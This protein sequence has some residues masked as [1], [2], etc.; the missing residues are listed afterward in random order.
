VKNPGTQYRSLW[1]PVICPQIPPDSHI[2]NN[3]AQD[4]YYYTRIVGST[5]AYGNSDVHVDVSNFTGGPPSNNWINAL[6]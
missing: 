3:Y 2:I 1:K 4:E 5:P 6:R